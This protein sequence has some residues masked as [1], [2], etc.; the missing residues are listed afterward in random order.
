MRNHISGRSIP[1]FRLPEEQRISC[2]QGKARQ[3]KAE[4]GKARQS[5]LGGRVAFDGR[6]TVTGTPVGDREIHATARL[7]QE[8]V[9]D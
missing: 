5:H 7:A 9:H 4:Q 8:G 2:K 1:R 3:S 6:F